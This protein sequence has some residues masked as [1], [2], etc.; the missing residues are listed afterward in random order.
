[1]Q[2]KAID[3]ARPLASEAVSL[4]TSRSIGSGDHQLKKKKKRGIGKNKKLGGAQAAA[5]EQQQQ[6]QRQMEIFW[7]KRNKNNKI[8]AYSK[9]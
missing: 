1:M 5:T 9:Q 6:Q 8:G 7:T 4:V 3:W 2:I